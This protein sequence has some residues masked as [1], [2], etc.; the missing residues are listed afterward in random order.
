MKFDMT[1]EESNQSFN[2]NVDGAVVINQ[3]GG[4]AEIKTFDLAA[5]GMSMHIIGGES[6]EIAVDTTEI[7]SAMREGVV[8]FQFMT[9]AGK[10]DAICN[11]IYAD[12]LG[13]WLAISGFMLNEIYGDFA[14]AIGENFVVLHSNV[15]LTKLDFRKYLSENEYQTKYNVERMIEDA[16]GVV[17]NGTY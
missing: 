13:T 15:R 16:L 4:V 8:R 7:I 5:M 11:Q 1:F 3:S 12:G 6:N 9:N 14:I 10:V 17:E 2:M